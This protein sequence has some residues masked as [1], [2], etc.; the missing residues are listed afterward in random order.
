M[1]TEKRAFL[2][3]YRS[4]MN[5]IDR[6]NNKLETINEK[7]GTI[8][9]PDLSGMPRGGTGKG[10]YDLVDEKCDLEKRIERLTSRSK[11]YKHKITEKID[12]LEDT[13]C[14]DVLELYF[15]ECCDF[16]DIAK[17]LNYSERHVRRLYT[18]GIDA[19]EL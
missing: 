5:S 18:Q 2:M 16:A 14:A 12:I 7:L 9:S 19:I 10:T 15:I 3:Q 4:I 11:I 8:R 17:R 13:R 6:L 1:N